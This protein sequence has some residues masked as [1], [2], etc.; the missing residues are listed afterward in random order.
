VDPTDA[1][2]QA[3]AMRY[4]EQHCFICL[5]AFAL[6]TGR[7][8]ASSPY[9]KY[10]KTCP[11]DYDDI[12]DFEE[13][14]A[15][16]LEVNASEVEITDWIEKRPVRSRHH[17][18]MHRSRHGMD[19]DMDG[20]FDSRRGR[21]QMWQE[22]TTHSTQ[23]QP[24]GCLFKDGHLRFND[25]QTTVPPAFKEGEYQIC[26]YK[27]LAYCPESWTQVI[28]PPPNIT[29][30]ADEETKIAREV[31]MQ[32]CRDTVGCLGFSWNN[33]SHCDLSL[34]QDGN[35]SAVLALPQYRNGHCMRERCPEGWVARVSLDPAELD[36]AR[37]RYDDGTEEIDESHFPPEHRDAQASMTIDDCADLCD[38][39]PECTQFFWNPLGH[40]RPSAQAFRASQDWK[41]C[42]LYR[43][44][45]SKLA[46][47]PGTIYCVRAATRCYSVEPFEERERKGQRLESL[48]V[49]GDKESCAWKCDQE[50]DCNSFAHHATDGC[51]LQELKDGKTAS[52]SVEQEAYNSAPFLL[53]LP[54]DE[55]TLYTKKCNVVRLPS[56]PELAMPL[57]HGALTEL[58][59]IVAKLVAYFF[60]R[61]QAGP[62]SN[63]G[64]LHVLHK[65]EGR[66]DGAD[67]D[68]E[69]SPSDLWRLL[70]V[71]VFLGWLAMMVRARMNATKNEAK[72]A[73][74]Q[75]PEGSS[76]V[77][78]ATC[79]EVQNLDYGDADDEKPPAAS[80]S[81]HRPTLS[82]IDRGGGSF[83]SDAGFDTLEEAMSPVYEVSTD[84]EPV[85]QRLND[86]PYF[87]QDWGITRNQCQELLDTLRADS[88]WHSSNT[89]H[90]MVDDFIRPWTNEKGVGYALHLNWNAPKQAN[91][92]VVHAWD[93]NAE[94]FLEVLI[95]NMGPRDVAFSAA[96][97]LYHCEDGCGPSVADQMGSE[98]DT[99]PSISTIRHIAAIGKG[100]F[101]DG[102]LW[103]YQHGLRVAPKVVLLFALWLGLMPTYYG[104][105]PGPGSDSTSTLSI[106]HW[107]CWSLGSKEE[108][109]AASTDFWEEGLY[110]FRKK[111]DLLKYADYV[112]FGI[113][114][115][116]NALLCIA[117]MWMYPP[118]RGRVLVIPCYECDTWR[119]LWCVYEIAQAKVLGVPY[120]VANTLC[121]M[122][123]CDSFAVTNP[124]TNKGTCASPV[125]EAEIRKEL[126]RFATDGLIRQ[127]SRVPRCCSIRLCVEG[128]RCCVEDAEEWNSH[129]G[130]SR[131]AKMEREWNIWVEMD[132]DIDKMQ[133]RGQ[134]FVGCTWFRWL[135]VYTMLIAADVGL[136]YQ[137]DTALFLAAMFGAIFALIIRFIGVFV[138]GSIVGPR[139]NGR[140][141]LRWVVAVH[142]ILQIIN[143]YTHVTSEVFWQSQDGGHWGEQVAIVVSELNMAIEF[144]FAPMLLV[145]FLCGT[146]DHIPM[147]VTVMACLFLDPWIMK[148]APFLEKSFSGLALWCIQVLRHVFLPIA[149]VWSLETWGVQLRTWGVYG[150]SLFAE[151]SHC[152]IESKAREMAARTRRMRSK[153]QRMASKR[154]NSEIGMD[155][156]DSREVGLLDEAA[157]G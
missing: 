67:D 156:H 131:R 30:Y 76:E 111:D 129:I 97:S 46:L 86:Q 52:S 44:V 102:I 73:G 95:R 146:C 155:G 143:V 40:A 124:D 15:A 123:Y 141:L 122:R 152:E 66:E 109:L 1:V 21:L 81:S 25:Q 148:D 91:V 89:I 49:L 157:E 2:I 42:N 41:R 117:A 39:R 22:I 127:S 105:L 126:R 149:Q 85:P 55:W 94:D 112:M 88:R 78:A 16:A 61:I 133:D 8:A 135:G 107:T 10:E 53:P 23:R 27:P 104:C 48:L 36:R 69:S 98:L 140:R 132:F 130:A 92:M 9:F 75:W 57:G 151:R 28:K 79:G 82:Y 71:V 5:C 108:P 45:P 125:D 12:L 74:R 54:N 93:G 144:T 35:R 29:L 70:H 14:Q 119:R 51:I 72:F 145:A 134:T 56:E 11:D 34:A 68:E 139:T 87:A 62:N 80:Y 43:H 63:L 110:P 3:A 84:V 101:M 47:D 116:S 100:G 142:C 64:Y 24:Q 120:E 77:E 154:M 113:L 26:K 17:M 83:A 13:C 153:K 20:D 50:A 90:D 150:D 106:N 138:I 115:A 31:C 136:K 19:D 60:C 6:S 59:R 114:L 128:L 58:C 4:S 99:C 121:T 96:L 137:Y 7:A 65:E 37:V 18:D 32:N 103:R 118:Y 33:E 147:L 38:R